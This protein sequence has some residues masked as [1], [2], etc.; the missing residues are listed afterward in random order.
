[1]KERFT[2]GEV[3]VLSFLRGNFDR[4]AEL[5]KMKVRR[6]TPPPPTTTTTATKTK[7]RMEGRMEGNKQA[8][9]EGHCIPLCPARH[10]LCTPN[11]VKKKTAH[12]PSQPPTHFLLTLK[13]HLNQN[14]HQ[15]KGKD[16]DA[17]RDWTSLY[18][19]VSEALQAK[20]LVPWLR[21]QYM[22]V[23]FQI[24]FDATVRVSLDTNLCMIMED[25]G[26]NENRWYR[27][28][29][30]PVP[31][32]EI[33]WF[34]HAVLEVKLQVQEGMVQPE[35]VTN[36]I[37]SGLLTEVHKF[38][39]FIHGCAT[40]FP[41]DV[42]AVPYWTDDDS[43]R[44]SIL[45]SG[46]GVIEQRNLDAGLYADVLGHSKS[47]QSVLDNKNK[48]RKHVDDD[49]NLATPL[50]HPPKAAQLNRGYQTMV[51]PA[52]QRAHYHSIQIEDKPEG[53]PCC[54]CP[55][56][57][58]WLPSTDRKMPMKIEPKVELLPFPSSR[59]AF[60]ASVVNTQPLPILPS[61]PP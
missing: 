39:K 43:I 17:L 19:E 29:D 36:L 4:D 55:M 48:P 57:D 21:T 2:L 20:Q 54:P 7:K 33:T 13:M 16:E 51:Q 12:L 53:T 15:A 61:P 8:R 22:R 14:A 42:Q 27:D 6:T 40:L 56:A 1:V 49:D 41:D 9:K 60:V 38:S 52:Q 30:K 45:R 32:N 47:D 59:I 44:E 11:T 26:G 58:C 46:G 24:P 23:A 37:D 25:L 3:D 28:S 50:N 34:P 31:H 5:E 18:N 10:P 35:W